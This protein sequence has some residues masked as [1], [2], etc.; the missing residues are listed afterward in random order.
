MFKDGITYFFLMI[1]A[2][3][4]VGIFIIPVWVI[5]MFR[6]VY[7]NGDSVR[8]FETTAIGLDQLGGSIL[9]LEPDWTI[10]SRTY[11]LSTK[12]NK[13]ATMFMLFINFFFGTDHCEKSFYNEFG[14]IDIEDM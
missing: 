4:L 11:Y 14:S 12:G 8:L 5:Q 2:I 10:S 13:K 9:Y 1:V 7:R 6:L 3:V